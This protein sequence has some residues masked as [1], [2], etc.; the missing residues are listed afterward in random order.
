MANLKGMNVAA[1]MSLRNQVDKGLVGFGSELE[2]QL[3]S[4]SRL[5]RA[6]GSAH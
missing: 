2:K 4:R 6:I 5:L 1:L 3:A